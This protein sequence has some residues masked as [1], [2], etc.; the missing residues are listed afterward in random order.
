MQS[1]HIENA[2]VHNLRGVT[3]DIPRNQL[4]VITG[5]SGS[6]KSSLVFDVIYAEGRRQYIESLSVYSR[7]F[8]HQL[9]RPDVEYIKGLQPT[10]AIDQ[11]SGSNNPRSTVATMTEVYDYLRILYS[12][13]GTAHCWN[14]GR[15][16]RQQTPEQIL[17]EILS[18]PEN[19]RIILLAPLIRGRRGQHAEVFRKIVKS[20]FVRARVDGV[21]VDAEQP[22]TLEPYRRHTIEAVID[23]LVLRD[24]IRPR[25]AESLKLAVKFGEGMVVA[26]YEKERIAN[27]DGTT[28]SVWKDLLYSTQYACPKCKISYAE[29][30]P[31]TFSF[32]S[33]YGACLDCQGMGHIEAFDYDLVVPDPRLSI[34]Q[35]GIAAFK[36]STPVSQQLYQSVLKNFWRRHGDYSQ[37]PIEEMDAALRELLFYG[38]IQH[39]AY[40]FSQG[41]FEED[42]EDF[43]ENEN[44]AHDNLDHNESRQENSGTQ[45][46]EKNAEEIQAQN[47]AQTSFPG[48]LKLLDELYQTA[49]SKKERDQWRA[50]RGKVECRACRGSRLRREASSVTIAKL[51]IHEIC[52]MTAEKS[53][54]FFKTLEFPEEL[55]L[56]TTPILEQIVLRLDFLNRVG[57][58][59]LTL[60][61]AADTLSGGERQR[62]Q[63]VSGLGTGLVGVCYVLDEP[64][65]G[66]HPRDNQRLI[67]AMRNLQQRGNTV[68]V[69]EHDEAIMREADWLIDFGP[70]AGRQGGMIVAEGTP[71]DV[72]KNPQSLTGNYLSGRYSIPVPK[73]RRKILK[74]R[75]LT[76]EGCTLH[77]LKNATVAF[78]LGTLIC[79]TGVSGSGKSSLLNETLVPAM[80]QYLY[81]GVSNN[82][83]NIA[84]DAQSDAIKNG[85]HYYGEKPGPYRRLKAANKIDKLIRIDQSP[86]GRS[87]RSNPATYTGVFDEIRKVFAQTRDARRRGYKL[88]RFSFN[89][90][91]GR[92]ET[93]QGQGLRKIEMHFLP[94]M[95][96]VCPECNGKRFNRQTLDVRY[97]DKSIA[98]VLEMAAAEAI[99][100]FE[101]I[102]S[103]AR[104][105]DS[106]NRVGLGY[107]TLGQS[108]TTLSG[109]EAQ[110]IKLAA[111]L[112]RVETGNTLYVLDEPTSGLHLH[113][114]KQLLE[115]LT[116]L[117]ELGNTVIV[118]E[119]NLDVAKTADWVIDLGPEG[120]ERGGYVLAE[121]TP[122]QVAALED[123]ATGRHLRQVLEASKR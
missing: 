117:V 16:I 17:E 26:S 64:S 102:P 48:L 60:D 112:S 94:D 13:A 2:R 101:N 95:Y 88:G 43:D 123:N 121:G 115:V 28:R 25:M 104:I 70:G 118:I 85:T 30:E 67:A 24:G 11:K 87:P 8:L 44:P 74:S 14:C 5:P 86:I 54:Q 58:D 56:V 91:G 92:C 42:D 45:N 37:T 49:K 78:P 107:L 122:E 47:T 40:A 103:I 79:V 114:V 96:A 105:L 119:H 38:E 57:L 20:G 33:P 113:D 55:R 68:L 3:L 19:C 29:L 1:L 108:S 52:A 6:G 120:G 76:L 71:A 12:R 90:A 61:R 10:I 34:A 77:N 69:V 111:E 27:P 99:A 73:K 23:R 80:M 59:Y 98:D 110:R 35:G 106:L 51:H 93:C 36:Q 97:K 4:V 41:D 32:N 75:L 63:L 109:G 53:L 7:Q 89:V 81:G 39:D 116:E 83:G 82:H 62:V 31:R 72:E 21:I 65:I 46:Q 9:E 50:F 15:A 22:P 18:L 84:C 66:L 100:F